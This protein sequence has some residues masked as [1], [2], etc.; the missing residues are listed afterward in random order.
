MLHLIIFTSPTYLPFMV[1]LIWK[2]VTLF[3][4]K[5]LFASAHSRKSDETDSQ[6]SCSAVSSCGMNFTDTHLMP[7]ST[8][9]IL[10]YQP[11]EIPCSSANS[12]MKMLVFHLFSPNQEILLPLH[13]CCS[14][15]DIQTTH[16]FLQQIY[17][18]MPSSKIADSLRTCI[19]LIASS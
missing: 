12:L 4:K 1:F 9:K 7:T 8:V 19:Q 2:V 6:F 16:H 11:E 5:F 18:C 3:L 10:L 15:K 17:R 13:H 14:T